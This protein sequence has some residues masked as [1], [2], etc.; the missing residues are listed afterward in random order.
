MQRLRRLTSCEPEGLIQDAEI[1][2]ARCRVM[3][4]DFE[5]TAKLERT[6][7]ERP[8]ALFPDGL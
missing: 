6:G 4:D 8:A 5:R 1:R 7:H 3:S 2:H